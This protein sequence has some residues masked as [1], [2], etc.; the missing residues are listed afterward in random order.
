MATTTVISRPNPYV[1]PRPYKQGEIIYGRERETSELL[2]LLIAERIILLYSPSGAGK[3]SLLNASI[4]PKMGEQGFEVWPTM[5]VNLEPPPDADQDPAF[6]RYVYSCLLSIEEAM[7][8]AKRFPANELASL[9]F[10]DYIARFQ[11]R[12][13][14]LNPEYNYP[15]ILLIFD[16]AE[17]VIRV[18]MTDRDKKAEFFLQ[19]GEVL[20]DRNIWAL[21]SI[22]EDYLAS[23]DSFVRPIPTRLANRYRLNFL[24]AEAALQAIQRPAAKSGVEFPDECARSLGDDLRKVLIQQPDGSTVEELGPYVEPVQLQVV[25]RRL[26]SQLPDD[27]TVVTQEHI[28]AL[29]NVNRA[30]G[31]YYSLQVASV[32]GISRVPERD[33]REWFDRKLITVSGIRGQVLMTPGQSDGLENKAIWLLERAYLI[34]AEKRGG[35]TWFE[36]AHDR[37][38][39]PIRENNGEWFDNNLSALQRQADVWN[40]QGRPDGMLIIGKDFIEMKKWADAN[41]ATMT[42]VEKDFYSGSL[43]AY[44]ND[45]RE[46]RNNT[47]IR[48]L[49]VASVITAVIA[50]GFFFQA[51]IAEQNAVARSLAAA[52]LSNLGISPERSTLLALA[53]L[54]VTG[55][56]RQEIVQALHQALPNM[57]VVHSSGADSHV[58]R[59]N[60]A[61]Y[62]PPDGK[63]LATA[64]QDGTVKIWDADSLV[65]LKTLE[66]VP[67]ITRFS[68]NGVYSAAYSPDGKSLA[69]VDAAGKLTVWDT[70]TWQVRYQETRLGQLYAVAYSHDGQ[71]IGTAGADRTAQIWEAASGKLV[72]ELGGKDGHSNGVRAIV[73]SLDDKLVFTGGEDEKTIRAWDLTTG[74]LAYKLNAPRAEEATVF[75]FALSPDGKFLATASSDRIVRIWNLETREVMPIPGHLDYVY[76]LAYTA[77][78]KTLISASADRTIRLWDTTYGRSQ[79]VLTGPADQVIGIALS[80]DGRHLASAGADYLVEIWDILA[81]GSREVLTMNHQDR[82]YD[83]A[84]SP[85]GKYIASAGVNRVINLWDASSGALVKQILGAKSKVQVLGW[86]KDAH[87][88]ASGDGGGTAILWDVTAGT[89]VTTIPSAG[90]VYGIWGISI[91]PDGKLLATS[92]GNGVVHVYDLQSKTELAALN[93]ELSWSSGAL[94]SPDG[95]YVAAGYGKKAIVIWD[96]QAKTPWLKLEGHTA[97]I[98]NIAYSKDGSMLASG[99]DDGR[100]IIWD[101]KPQAKVRKIAILEGHRGIVYDVAFSPDGKHLVSGSADGLVKIW[102]VATGTQEYDLY[103]YTN[104]VY[105]VAFSPDGKHIVSSSADFSI[106]VFTT[107]VNELATLARQ[108]VT[109][110]LTRDECE[111]NFRMS[112]AEFTRPSLL[113]S[114]T[115]FIARLFNQ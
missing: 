34:R 97:D 93:A 38:V 106:R 111:V 86:S 74:Q 68:G 21:F 51:R 37:L 83:V 46:R 59:V 39:R 88:L 31:D 8:E 77:D 5:R 11:E 24:S 23:F 84:F 101:L 47:M 98:E 65:V 40:T 115:N 1:G 17:E 33:I 41:R 22:R 6:N 2:D 49:F 27:A 60:T 113:K 18:S 107:D 61:V 30:L 32:A 56:P 103:G 14:S 108:R 15:S 64:S 44:E 96:W 87:Y 20:R 48:W 16:Q 99:S 85:D 13:L 100:I 69:A 67:D 82:V 53:G 81:D 19:V 95:K 80:P 66:V 75:G 54:D 28:D 45:L 89:P 102:N 29:G 104:R 4:F 50:I 112:C 76:S 90:E 110:T 94:F 36:L 92:D 3:S 35:A 10:R 109:R 12:A 57:R 114:L 71:Y 7:P 91:S 42:Q 52:A 105:A 9:K 43:K 70:A 63:Y 58:G 55:Q 62:S 73:F 78:G 72:L 79:M 26:W 25:C